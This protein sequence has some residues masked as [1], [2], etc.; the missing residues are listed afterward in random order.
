MFYTYL[1]ASRRHG[2]LYCGHTDDL[3]VRMQKHREGVFDGFTKKYGVH[4]LVWYEKHPAREL[5]F[6]R[7]RQIKKWNRDW[8]ISLIEADNPH[9][10]DLT[11][12][13]TE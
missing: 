6:R 12:A 11:M 2:T 1:L 4:T 3:W 7:E 9:W 10:I 13:I 8:K 5:A